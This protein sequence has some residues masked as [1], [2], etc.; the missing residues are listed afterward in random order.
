[1]LEKIVAEENEDVPV[2]VGSQDFFYGPGASIDRSQ[3]LKTAMGC[4]KIVVKEDKIV[5]ILS[6]TVENREGQKDTCT[7]Y[8]ALWRNNTSSSA[9]NN[10]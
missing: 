10:G 9:L 2:E 8:F 1:M 3:L 6:G 4:E 5:I 7:L